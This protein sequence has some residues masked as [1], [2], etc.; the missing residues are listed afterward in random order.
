[1]PAVNVWVPADLLD[2]ARTHRIP[3]SK[4]LQTVLRDTV[5]FLET[6][7]PANSTVADVCEERARAI[8]DDEA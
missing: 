6:S 4:A 5:S 2:A 7:S 8:G 3:M 1:M